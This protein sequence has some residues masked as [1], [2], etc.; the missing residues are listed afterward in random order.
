VAY[1]KNNENLMAKIG[2]EPRRNFYYASGDSSTRV[3]VAIAGAPGALGISGI[4][5]FSH[6]ARCCG[7]LQ[8]NSLGYSLGGYPAIHDDGGI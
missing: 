1:D 3:G 5:L 2:I 4:I 8:A 6:L 7:S